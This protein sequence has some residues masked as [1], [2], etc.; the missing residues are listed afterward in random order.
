M[1]PA[2]FHDQA[3]RELEDAL[4]WYEQRRPG[5]GR[6]FQFAV[7]DAIRRV[8]ENPQAGPR[9][10]TTRFH[11]VL[12]RRFPYVVFYSERADAIRIMAVAHGKR[13]PGYWKNRTT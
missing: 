13:R 4:A 10:G 8:C 5:L 11:Y 9:F 6:E 2:V 12:V 1:K 7:E 3:K